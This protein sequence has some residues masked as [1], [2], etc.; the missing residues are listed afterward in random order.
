M[1]FV[2]AEYFGLGPHMN[3]ST[4]QTA[5]AAFL[6]T[7][8]TLVVIHLVHV[9]FEAFLTGKDVKSFPEFTGVHVAALF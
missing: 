6:P 7:A 5:L 8:P 2:E 3:A 4:L 9:V 1:N